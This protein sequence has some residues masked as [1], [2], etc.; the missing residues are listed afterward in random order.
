MARLTP[1]I[2]LFPPSLIIGFSEGNWTKTNRSTVYRVRVMA[3]PITTGS[4]LLLLVSINGPGVC[5]K[6]EGDAIQ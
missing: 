1:A 2:F 6:E 5:R 3:M 4:A